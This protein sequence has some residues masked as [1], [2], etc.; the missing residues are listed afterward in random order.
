VTHSQ[1]I[2]GDAVTSLLGQASDLSPGGFGLL[3][4][5]PAHQGI[6]TLLGTGSGVGAGEARRGGHG[7]EGRRVGLDHVG[8]VL[9]AQGASGLLVRDGSGP[10]GAGQALGTHLLDNL[11]RQ[12][13]LRRPLLDSA[14]KGTLHRALQQ[15][16]KQEN[17]FWGEV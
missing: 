7:E 17:S 5:H 9:D 10:G 3:L 6:I 15:G 8:F 12:A 1:R 2:C 11:A 14:G 16:E 13:A 4:L